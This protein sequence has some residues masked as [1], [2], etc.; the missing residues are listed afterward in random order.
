[1]GV[2]TWTPEQWRAYN[3]RTG[4]RHVARREPPISQSQVLAEDLA[5]ERA[6][7]I[8]ERRRDP[9]AW[10]DAYRRREMAFVRLTRPLTHLQTGA[11]ADGS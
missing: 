10:V 5:Q 6:L 4:D 11:D 7:R 1:M 2:N 3:A 9:D 8:L